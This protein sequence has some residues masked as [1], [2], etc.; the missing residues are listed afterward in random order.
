M[1]KRVKL[2]ITGAPMVRACGSRHKR[3]TSRHTFVKSTK[4]YGFVAL[5]MSL[6]WGCV[7]RAPPPYPPGFVLTPDEPL[8]SIVDS[9]EAT[10][11]EEENKIAIYHGFACAKTVSEE[12]HG[13][14]LQVEQ[15]K[16]LPKA[17][18]RATV[19][20]N[21]WQ[22]IFL[23]DD[24]KV[25]G[26]GTVIFNIRGGGS[27][28]RRDNDEIKWHA[29][30]AISDDNYDDPFTWCYRYTLVA[31]NT[32]YFN[33]A[34]DHRDDYLFESDDLKRW[35]TALQYQPT[36]IEVKQYKP[37]ATILPRGFGFIYAGA[38]DHA[39]LQLAYNLDANERFAAGDS[40]AGSADRA[41]SNNYSWETKT[42]LKDDSTQRDYKTAEVVSVMSGPVMGVIQP[43]FSIVP[44]K[45][46]GNCVG[47]SDPET[48][49]R[50]IDD[51]P[52]DI[53]I[54]VLTGWDLSYKCD[55]E[56]VKQIGVWVDGFSFNPNQSQVISPNGLQPAGRLNYT[57]RFRLHDADKAEGARFRHRVSILGINRVTE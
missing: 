12:R 33:I 51:V 44:F 2:A 14:Y 38:D 10:I 45:D 20:L 40:T 46:L 30:G 49:P 48:S 41:A 17:L 16:S 26:L 22:F 57:M 43:P 9:G 56:N 29:A 24:H 35:G 54:P 19:F 50:T 53:A 4:R 39:L 6:L 27:V 28:E 11:L 42:V 1:L 25:A 7:F 5:A 34:A 47:P 13:F 32:S 15:S 18:D 23:D 21:G 8:A 52:F 55:D 31:W 36:S 3:S 37:S